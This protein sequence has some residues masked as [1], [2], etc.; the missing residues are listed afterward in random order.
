MRKGIS[1]DFQT[2]YYD[3]LGFFFGVEP[4]VMCNRNTA[5]II[6][7][8]GAV[9]TQQFLFLP[10]EHIPNKTCCETP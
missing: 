1:D 5:L 6:R 10:L 2:L 8:D 4:C 9:K 7:I 3:F